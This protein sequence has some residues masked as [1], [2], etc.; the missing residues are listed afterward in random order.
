MGAGQ[1]GSQ[2]ATFEM[3]ADGG[4]H[5]RFD[6]PPAGNG[7][8]AGFATRAGVVWQVDAIKGGHLILA[9]AETQ[10]L[11]WRLAAE[12]EAAITSGRECA[13]RRPARP[14][15]LPA[16]APAER[17]RPDAKLAAAAGA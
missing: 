4:W 1:P 11:A 12:E 5:A 17:P 9:W 8:E 2:S 7:G 6:R 16:S 3:T 10:T 13:L 14:R 15:R